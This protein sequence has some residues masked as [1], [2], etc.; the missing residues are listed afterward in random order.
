MIG[1][2]E[3]HV[4]D[5]YLRRANTILKIIRERSLN[6]MQWCSYNEHK[7]CSVLLKV[8]YDLYVVLSPMHSKHLKFHKTPMITLVMS[9]LNIYSTDHC[10]PQNFNFLLLKSINFEDIGNNVVH[11]HHWNT[12]VKSLGTNQNTGIILNYET[13]LNIDIFFQTY[14]KNTNLFTESKQAIIF[15]FWKGEKKSI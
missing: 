7:E 6:I 12:F 4:I 9:I 8:S 10:N 14:V 3:K 2:K 13:F 15:F 1:G 11:E 5:E